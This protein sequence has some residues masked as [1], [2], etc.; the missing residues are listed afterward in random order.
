[1]RHFWRVRFRLRTL[2]LAMLILGIS[3]WLVVRYLEWQEDQMWNTLQT[4]KSQRDMAI[5]HWRRIYD[6]V[7]AGEATDTHESD[8]RSQYYSARARVENAVK[9][10]NSYYGDDEKALIK[11]M[12]Q[13]KSRKMR[14]ASRIGSK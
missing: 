8:A 6:R 11:A 7:Q 10:V 4:A 5:V 13:R 3:P 9:E 12:E 2:L 1:M 14:Y